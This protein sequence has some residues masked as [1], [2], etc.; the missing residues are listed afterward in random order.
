MHV[1]ARF[2]SQLCQR[3]NDRIVLVSNYTDTGPFF[4]IVSERRYL[5]LRLDGTTSISKRQKLVNRFNDPSKPLIQAPMVA[6][7]FLVVLS[8]T[9]SYLWTINSI[10][11][12]RSLLPGQPR[13]HL[14]TTGLSIF[15]S[16]K[17]LVSGDMVLF[18]R[19][20]L[21]LTLTSFYYKQRMRVVFDFVLLLGHLLLFWEQSELIF[22]L[23]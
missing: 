23:N 1:L 14:L 15:V 10:D 7:P 20:F 2:L 19:L 16:Q 11:P 13:R 9:V 12:L 5:F 21:T 17:N 6:S 4:S 22:L 18:L 8:K 3:T